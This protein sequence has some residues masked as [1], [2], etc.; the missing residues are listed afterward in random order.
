MFVVV[1]VVWRHSDEK[2]TVIGNETDGRK[3]TGPP[4]KEN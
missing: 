3:R 1:V 2:T 4:P